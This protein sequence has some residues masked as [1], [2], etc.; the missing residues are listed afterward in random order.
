MQVQSVA[1]QAGLAR[2]QT[3]ERA[4]TARLIRSAV[5]ASLTVAVVVVADWELVATQ[6]PVQATTV[7]AAMMPE[8][9]P[10]PELQTV[11]A[12]AAAMAMPT[13]PTTAVAA[14]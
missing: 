5:V 8:P 12:V 11:A 2:L 14:L 6:Q 3:E 13:E 4:A 7:V 1:M 10:K 9:M